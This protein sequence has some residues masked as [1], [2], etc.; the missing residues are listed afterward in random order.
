MM[1]PLMVFHITIDR[2]KISRIENKAVIIPFGGYVKSDL[3]SG[4]ILPGACDVQT[5]DAAGIRHMCAKYMFEG[6]D[7][8]G[9][10]CRLFVEN[11]GWFE[12]G[13]R[14]AVFHATPTFMTDSEDLAEILERP[15]FRSE[16]HHSEAGVDIHIYKVSRQKEPV[17]VQEAAD[18]FL[19]ELQAAYVPQEKA[20]EMIRKI[21]EHAPVK[22][23]VFV[24][25]KDGK[26][27]CRDNPDQTLCEAAYAAVKGNYQLLFLL[28]EKEEL[29]ALTYLAGKVRNIEQESLGILME[30]LQQYGKA[31][32]FDKPVMQ[33]QRYRI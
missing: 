10:P 26:A 23:L 30:V 5:Y 19:K 17:Q 9:Q 2:T 27:H 14:P 7:M 16:G 29:I 15:C 8:N 25:Q 21:Q 6:K 11:N 18:D 13:S 12:P 31:D 24:S 28:N 22:K 33:Y 32:W 1:K 20:E 4:S 3:F